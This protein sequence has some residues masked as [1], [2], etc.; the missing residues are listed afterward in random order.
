VTSV[1]VIQGQV[2]VIFMRGFKNTLH[3]IL[4]FIGNQRIKAKEV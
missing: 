2:F 3:M 1:L 4:N